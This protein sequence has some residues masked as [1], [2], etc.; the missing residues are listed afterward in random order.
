VFKFDPPDPAKIAEGV[1]AL[2]ESGEITH[3]AARIVLPQLVAELRKRFDLSASAVR[4]IDALIAE[5]NDMPRPSL[6]R[7]DRVPWIM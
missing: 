2:L 3:R 7:P 4:P 6:G 5:L 1:R